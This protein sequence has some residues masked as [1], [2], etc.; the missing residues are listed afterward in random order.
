[1]S[2]I[3]SKCSLLYITE[4]I[5]SIIIRFFFSEEGMWRYVIDEACSKIVWNVQMKI[6]T[7]IV[8]DRLSLTTPFNKNLDSNIGIIWLSTLQESKVKQHGVR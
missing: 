2:S 4:I 8:C 5:S 3:S 6:L 1:M 7:S